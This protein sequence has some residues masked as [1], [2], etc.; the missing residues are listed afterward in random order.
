MVRLSANTEIT[1]IAANNVEVHKYVSIIFI[2]ENV[3]RVKELEYA[4]IQKDVLGVLYVVVQL[5][6]NIQEEKLSVFNVKE[7]LCVSI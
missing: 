1:N 2:D 5:Y 4:N 6:A 7:V 3:F